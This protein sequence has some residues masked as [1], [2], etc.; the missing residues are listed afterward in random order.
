MKWIILICV[1]ALS[2][3]YYLEFVEHLIPCLLCVAQRVA[4]YAIALFAGL[5]WLFPRHKWVRMLL[6]TGMLISASA[7]VFFAGKQLY[8]ESL[9]VDQRPACTVPFDMLIRSHE[10]GN[11]LLQ[12]LNGTSDC[13]TR[14]WVFLNMSLPFW[15]GCIFVVLIL[16]I[17]MSFIC[18]MSRSSDIQS[19]R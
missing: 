16:L 15:S 11:A 14:Q 3:G 8:L 2:A 4:L 17:L 19:G 10:W 5:L 7:G 13:G 1:A 6:R 9:P 18:H 12:L